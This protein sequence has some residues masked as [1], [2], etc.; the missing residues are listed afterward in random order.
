MQEL[1]LSFMKMAMENRAWNRLFWHQIGDI[2]VM[3]IPGYSIKQCMRWKYP[4]ITRRKGPVMYEKATRD[5]YFGG[6][7]YQLFEDANDVAGIS[8][9]AAD[10]A[11]A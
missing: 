6:Y 3:T 9:L 7:A 2:V 8:Q 4:V 5:A 1:K 10:R 11:E